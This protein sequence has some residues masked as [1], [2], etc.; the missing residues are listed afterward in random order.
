MNKLNSWL[1]SIAF[2]LLWVGLRRLYVGIQASWQTQMTDNGLYLIW[3][4][5]VFAYFV[6]DAGLILAYMYI[7]KGPLGRPMPKGFPFWFVASDTVILVFLVHVSF[8]CLDH[9]V[10]VQLRSIGLSLSYLIFV[11]ASTLW[12]IVAG[13][14]YL[15]VRRLYLRES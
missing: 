7:V 12:A 3:W 10:Y 9:P 14:R 15:F 2:G 11:V 5:I 6:A 4:G 13:L 8:A 1:V